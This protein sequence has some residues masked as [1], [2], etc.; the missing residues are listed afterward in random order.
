M[1]TSPAV[2]Y[3]QSKLR[4]SREQAPLVFLLFIMMVMNYLDRQALSV[5]APVMRKELGVSVMGYANA[6]NS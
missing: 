1:V 4:F 6:V 5:V 3:P 2:R